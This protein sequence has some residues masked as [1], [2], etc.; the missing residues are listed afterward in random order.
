MNKKQAKLI[1]NSVVEMDPN[2]S[3]PLENL[4]N[5][6]S[7]PSPKG[8]DEF[9]QNAY[10][11]TRAYKVSIELTDTGENRSHWKIYKLSFVSTNAIKI[12]GWLLVPSKGEVKRA[13]IVGHGYGGRD[14]P[15]FHLPFP[16]TAIY[17]PC[18]RGISLSSHYPISQDPYWHVIHDIDKKDQYILRGCVEDTWLSVSALEMLYPHLANKIFYMGMSFTGGIGVL[19]LAQDTRIAKA[20]FNVPTFGNHKLRLRIPTQGS[21][22]SLQDFYHREPY[23]LIR[24]LRYYDAANAAKRIKVPTHFALALRDSVVTPPGQFAIYNQIPD[25]KSLFVLDA[26]HDNYENQDQQHAELLKELEEF[27]S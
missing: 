12:N 24:T 5:I 8:F 13:M 2:K 7:P 23:K 21:G 14:A 18:C 20:H 19:A 27:F 22:K 17:F 15:D 9:W 26:G 16:D 6:S 1:M 11:A 10:Q 4:L 3:Y 25:K